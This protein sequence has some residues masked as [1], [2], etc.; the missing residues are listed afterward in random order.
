MQKYGVEFGSHSLTHPLL[1]AQS[2]AQLRREV[3]D[4]K[5][6]LEDLLGLEVM[7]FAYPF[8]RVD[9]RVRGA[10]VDA[11]CR[12]AFTAEPGLNSSNDPLCQR[13]AEVN[14]TTS[15]ADFLFKLQYGYGIRMVLGAWRSRFG[16]QI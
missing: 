14:D 10:V 4:S 11:G 13:R 6:R 5:H 1:P 2:D 12:L 15:A 3:S 16:K 9:G 7:S 8:G